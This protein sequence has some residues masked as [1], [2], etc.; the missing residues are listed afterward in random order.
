MPQRT[1][2]GTRQPSGQVCFQLE[3]SFVLTNLDNPPGGIVV[4]D[5]DDRQTIATGRVE[6]LQGKAEAAIACGADGQ[7]CREAQP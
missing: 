5:E 3:P 2:P 6:F 4:D 7:A 1:V